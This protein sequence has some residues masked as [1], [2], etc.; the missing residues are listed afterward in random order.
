MNNYYSS[1]A[2]QS[3]FA[4]GASLSK[5]GRVIIAIYS[6][7]AKGKVSTIVPTL[8]MGAPVTTSKNVSIC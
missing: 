1:T 7:A 5:N 4:K 3:D 8:L 6:T 2:G